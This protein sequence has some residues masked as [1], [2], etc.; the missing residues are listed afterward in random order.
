MTHE[1]DCNIF[2]C[3]RLRINAVSFSSHVLFAPVMCYQGFF[4][5]IMLRSHEVHLVCSNNST[6]DVFI[7]SNI[8]TGVFE[9]SFHTCYCTY[10]CVPLVFIQNHIVCEQ[11]Y[12]CGILKLTPSQAISRL[13]L[14]VRFFVSYEES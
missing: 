5:L 1:H 9:S 13:C 11:Q 10:L 4:E 7:S 2:L 12:S 14:L 3:C 8:F 6:I